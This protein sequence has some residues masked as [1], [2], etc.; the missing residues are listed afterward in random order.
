MGCGRNLCHRVTGPPTKGNRLCSELD[1]GTE[2]DRGKCN[3]V[4]R[5]KAPTVEAKD[6]IDCKRRIELFQTACM[7]VKRIWNTVLSTK[8]HKK[9]HQKEYRQF[10]AR[11]GSEDFERHCLLIAM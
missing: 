4:S 5:V 2:M 11:T 3:E 1:A 10:Q 9:K 6:A 7:E 8:S